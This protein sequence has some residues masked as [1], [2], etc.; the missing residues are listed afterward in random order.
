[1]TG[2][3]AELQ[4]DKKI[5]PKN[6]TPSITESD[7]SEILTNTEEEKKDESN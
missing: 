1:M 4:D 3:T 7:I 6:T 2:L 5:T